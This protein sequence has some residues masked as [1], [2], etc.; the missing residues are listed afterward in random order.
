[1]A[2]VRFLRRAL[3]ALTLTLGAALL[4]GCGSD[5]QLEALQADVMAH[6]GP[7]GARLTV[8]GDREGSNGGLMGKPSEAKLHRLFNMPAGSDGEAQ[9]RAALKVAQASGWKLS[10]YSLKADGS[11]THGSSTSFSATKR[12]RTGPARLAVI[13][14]R[15]EAM[16]PRQGI[17]APWLSVYLT[18]HR[19]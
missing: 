11:M 16:S 7:A 8:S 5:P 15:D 9:V 4:S 1:M 6:Y 19:S 18:H 14:E 10:P 3:L 17:R 12:L 2:C 13:F